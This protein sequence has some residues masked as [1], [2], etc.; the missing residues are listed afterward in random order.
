MPKTDAV[1]RIE[2]F[3]KPLPLGVAI[4][5]VESGGGLSVAPSAKSMGELAATN[6][7]AWLKGKSAALQPLN[8]QDIRHSF[9]LRA[10][11]ADVLP[12]RSPQGIRGACYLSA[13][14]A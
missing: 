11:G 13:P 1:R 14:A 9:S 5:F 6:A 3:S 2:A 12:L 10:S 8:T 4:E 7:L